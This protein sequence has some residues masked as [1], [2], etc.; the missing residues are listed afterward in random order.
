M[1]ATA[2]TGDDLQHDGGASHSG[3]RHLSL[4]EYLGSGAQAPIARRMYSR[5]ADADLNSA[6]REGVVLAMDEVLHVAV[7][8]VTPVH[9]VVGVGEGHRTVAAGPLATPGAGAE[10]R[11]GR[12]TRQAQRAADVDHR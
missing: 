8:A 4:P 12:R 1:V 6:D 9:E 10:R 7:A 3:S 2:M 5:P 11:A